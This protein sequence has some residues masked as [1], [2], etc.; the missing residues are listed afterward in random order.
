MNK[1]T[2]IVLIVFNDS[3]PYLEGDSLLQITENAFQIVDSINSTIF[4][5][6]R[7]DIFKLDQKYYLTPDGTFDVYKWKDSKWINLYKYNFRGYNFGSKKFIFNNKIHSFG[8]Y[9]FWRK[10]GQIIE[11]LEDKGEWELLPFS[12]A[13]ENGIASLNGKELQV[14][15]TDSIYIYNLEKRT[16][17]TLGE[18]KIKNNEED[19]LNLNTIKLESYTFKLGNKPHIAF[20]KSNRH[21]E[22]SQLSPFKYFRD[23]K[24]NGITHIKG[25]EVV[26][27]D[28]KLNLL[29]DYSLN[30]ELKFFTEELEIDPENEKDSNK[31]DNYIFLLVIL[32]F[33]G[34]LIGLLSLIVRRNKNVEKSI[35][36]TNYSF[37][38]LYIKLAQYSGQTLEQEKLDETLEISHIQ[39]PESRR[40]KRSQLIKDFNQISINHNSSNII[41]RERDPNDGR[42]YVYKIHQKNT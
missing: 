29:G 36:K 12:E 22:I 26:C 38:P 39:S 6:Q 18:S 11:F 14:I 1:I 17:T 23:S 24:A 41:Q 7:A 40:F 20:N 15:G 42:K 30:T 33:A 34:L 32:T 31:K 37:P 4:N 21:V 3:Q 9:G 2:F 19:V 13:F 35:Q 27:Y 5:I 16:T 10:H 8:G 25:D 28:R